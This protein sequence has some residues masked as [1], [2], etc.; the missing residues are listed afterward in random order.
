VLRPRVLYAPVH[1]SVYAKRMMLT[2]LRQAQDDKGAADGDMFELKN[3][4]SLVTGGS[5][6]IGK[7]IAFALG[8]AGAAVAIN[9]RERSVEAKAVAEAIR[10]KGGRAEAFAGDVSLGESVQRMVREVEERLGPIDVLVNNAGTAASPGLDEITE[11]DFDRSIAVNLKSAFLSSSQASSHVFRLDVQA[12]A[13]R[14]RRRS[15]CS[16]ATDT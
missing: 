6:G 4:V 9:F 10:A 7:A 12:R 2:V 11:E 16:S 14:S 13:A 5:R 3:R 15:C 1:C 8:E